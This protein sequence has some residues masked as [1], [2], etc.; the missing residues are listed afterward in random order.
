[1]LRATSKLPANNVTTSDA[2]NPILN[3]VDR[4]TAAPSWVAAD[5]QTPVPRIREG[6]VHQVR[7]GRPGSAPAAVPDGPTMR[8]ARAADHPAAA[9]AAAAGTDSS[10][11]DR[12]APSRA[13]RTP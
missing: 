10:R 3:A 9:P 11:S 12:A 8:A 13:D 5:Q 2:A 4:F 1:M 7:A 6:P